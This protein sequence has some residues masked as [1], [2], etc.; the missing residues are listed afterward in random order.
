MEMK[1]AWVTKFVSMIKMI[2]HALFSL[3]PNILDPPLDV[4][5]YIDSIVIEEH[6]ISDIVRQLAS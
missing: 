3:P 2:V 4:V 1:W 6:K 5:K